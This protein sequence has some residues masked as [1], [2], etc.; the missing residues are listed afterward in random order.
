[1]KLPLPPREI[2]ACSV[3]DGLAPKFLDKLQAVCTALVDAGWQPILRE[4]TRS[5]ERAAF[6]YGFGREYD[7]GR[8]VVTNAPNGLK[9]WH[10]FGL[11]ADLGDRR[12]E[13]GSEPEGFWNALGA[14]AS[15][16]GL[17]WGGSWHFADKPHVQFGPPMRVSPSD[18]AARLLAEGGV[19]AVWRAVGAA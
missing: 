19:E 12:Y 11:A 9:T 1:M 8:G 15:T 3:V 7:D 14:A 4:T 2:P 18:D 16:H 13:P 10:R 17:T 5:D 6:L